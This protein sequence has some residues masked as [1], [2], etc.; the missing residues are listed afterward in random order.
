[1]ALWDGF[2]EELGRLRAGQ[3][4]QQPGQSGVTTEEDNTEAYIRAITALPEMVV[5]VGIPDDADQPH[6]GQRPIG[7]EARPGRIGN[8]TLGYIHEHGAPSVNIPAR[9]FLYPGVR[10]SR[11]QWQPH[12]V[13]AGEAALEGDQHKM[14]QELHK[15]GLVAQREVRATIQRGIPPPLS[16][17]T[18]RARRRRSPG[19]SYRRRALTPAD[20]TPLID[21]GALLRSVSYV[22]KRER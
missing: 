10:D 12:L 14:M 5:L 16:P 4:R 15:T 7:P 20:V 19:S 3:R 18:V 17:R 22:V 9:P 21:T 8:A 1:M 13:A 6:E 11:D 2:L